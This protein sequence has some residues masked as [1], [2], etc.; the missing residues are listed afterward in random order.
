MGARAMPKGD[1]WTEHT[2][3]PRPRTGEQKLLIRIRCQSREQAE[4]HPAQTARWWPRW[5]HDGGCG[6]IVE[7]KKA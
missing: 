3:G 2:G 4:N 7:W 5:K 1:D 6:D